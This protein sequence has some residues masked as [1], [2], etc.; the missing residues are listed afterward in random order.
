MNPSRP[1]SHLP[2]GP[3]P[4]A[5]TAPVC[6]AEEQD[7]VT[8]LCAQAGL[9]LLQHGAE[10]AL[11]ESVARRL[12]LAL[13]M[14]AVEIA[15]MANGLTITTSAGGRLY[16]L[17]RR[18]QDRGINMQMVT[19][20]QR[21]V[22]E[23]EAGALDRAGAAARLAGLKPLRYNRWLVAGVVGLS[24]AAFARLILQARGL[25]TDAGTIGFA[26]AAS[27]VAMLVRQSLAH[28][29]FNPLVTFAAAAF[30]ATSV[31]AQG[32]IHGWT[33]QPKIAL[34]ASVLLLVPGYPLINAVSDMVK[35]YINTGIS[36]GV[37]AVLLLLASCGGIVLAMTVWGTW[38]WL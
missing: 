9:T 17:V 10:S 8:R 29:H 1:D 19:E 33:G 3:A 28:R 34:A 26:F 31:A 36:R 11:V 16:T 37:M 38:A 23:V 6:S 30:V 18:N 4:Q 22:L 15:L 35:G 24:C 25:P 5:A 12:G 2:S 27:A 20:V 21:A 32:V 14:E 7:E 13:G